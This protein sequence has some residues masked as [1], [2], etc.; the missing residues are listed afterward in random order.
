MTFH[1]KNFYLKKFNLFLKILYI[2]YILYIEKRKKKKIKLF[3]NNFKNQLII[4]KI[5]DCKFKKIHRFYAILLSPYMACK[6]FSF[7]INFF[8]FLCNYKICNLFLGMF[9]LILIFLFFIIF[10]F[11]IISFLFL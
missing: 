2:L 9:L 5:N 7:F 10:Y 3:F 8:T 4:L 11:I 1:L 6:N